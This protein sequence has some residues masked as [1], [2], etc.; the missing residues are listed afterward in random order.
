M[1]QPQI[2]PNL[3][4]PGGQKCGSSSLAYYLSLHPDCC[5]ST[6]KEPSFFSRQDNLRDLS[7]YER[8]FR[9]WS[10]Q[11]IL[12]EASTGYLFEEYAAT[13]IRNHL[14]RLKIVIILRDPL[15]RTLSAYLH[16][17][18][19]YD[20]LRGF[21]EVFGGLPVSPAAAFREEERRIEEAISTKKIDKQRYSL[22][23]DDSLWPFRY[24]RNSWY[25]DPVNRYLTIFGRENVH[26]VLLEDLEKDPQHT[27]QGVFEFLGVQPYWNDS[28][29]GAENSTIL[30]PL[31]NLY[32]SVPPPGFKRM[33]ETIVRKA[34][35]KRPSVKRHREIKGRIFPN[36]RSLLGMQLNELELATGMNLRCAWDA[37][38]DMMKLPRSQ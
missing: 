36:L 20:D 31:V 4:I 7:S 1:K 34:S 29:L 35:I 24:L 37:D 2:P 22:R 28:F 18:K 21:E 11:T 15:G 17:K 9:Q 25:I 19:R 33:L 5:I 27:M 16:L 30:P 10:G 23:Y 6:P 26:I 14:N 13:R 32:D 8:F 38:L 12:F 3:I